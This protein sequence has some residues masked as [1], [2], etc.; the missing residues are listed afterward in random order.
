M[1]AT[2]LRWPNFDNAPDHCTPSA[3][4]ARRSELA[5][6]IADYKKRGG[7]ITQVPPNGRTNNLHAS[8]W[9]KQPPPEGIRFCTKRGIYQIKIGNRY[10]GNFQSI[11]AADAALNRHKAAK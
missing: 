4:A 10:S 6:H 5:E 9:K 3:A 2:H 11:P 1:T 7:K 8:D